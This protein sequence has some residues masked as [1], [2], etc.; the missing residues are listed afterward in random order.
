MNL[1]QQSGTLLI[2]YD[3]LA[4]RQSHVSHLNEIGSSFAKD[5][6]ITLSTIEA[7]RKVARAEIQDLLADRRGEV[8]STHDIT[9]DEEHKGRLLLSHGVDGEAQVKE[10]LGWG[11][12]AGDTQDAF[13]RL[14]FAGRA[15]FD[16]R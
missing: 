3:K 11:N 16:T 5:K 13:E 6:E 9:G 12:V 10:S 2:A 1:V 14:C 7:G 15:E 8:R 4:G